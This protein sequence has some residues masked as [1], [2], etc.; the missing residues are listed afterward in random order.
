MPSRRFCAVPK[1]QSSQERGESKSPLTAPREGTGRL[2]K[3]CNQGQP[4]GAPELVFQR[5][6]KVKEHNAAK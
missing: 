5:N 2:Q 4:Q 3:G 1:E 6:G